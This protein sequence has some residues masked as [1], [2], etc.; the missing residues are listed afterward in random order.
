MVLMIAYQLLV[1][2]LSAYFLNK[3]K[4]RQSSIESEQNQFT[5]KNKY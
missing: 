5:N 4:N 1:P 2:L 3:E